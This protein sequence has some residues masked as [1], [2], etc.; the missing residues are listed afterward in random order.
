MNKRKL[1]KIALSLGALYYLVGSYAHYFGLTL[2]PWFDGRLYVPYQDTLLALVDLILVYFL[3]VVARDP[4]KNIDMLRA[5]I[6]SGAIAS[7]FS[8]VIVGKVDFAAIGAPGKIPQTI[9]EGILG[10][11][12]VGILLSLYPKEG[13]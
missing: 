12:W 3:L 2:F 7:L 11:V 13:K 4:V 5:I 6:V 10:F 1:L 9:T 8:I